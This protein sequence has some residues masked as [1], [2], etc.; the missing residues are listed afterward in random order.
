MASDIGPEFRLWPPVSVGA[1]LFLGLLVSAIVGDPLHR[2]PV[3]TGLG[4]VLIAAFACWNG[5]ALWT[6]RTYRTALLPGGP[7]TTV[8]VS[9]PFKRS[10]NPLY[11]GLIAGSAGV[12]LVT[13]SMWALFGLPVEWVLLEWGAVMPEER[14]LAAKFGDSYTDYTQRV[15]RWL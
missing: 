5:W 15:R 7:T 13:A 10:R 12:S 6:I 8:I 9:G 14:Y 11:L 2:S 1:P 3:T 4:W